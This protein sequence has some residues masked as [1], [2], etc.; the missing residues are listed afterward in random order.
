MN[1]IKDNNYLEHVK[2]YKFNKNRNLQKQIYN[3][4]LD[5]IIKGNL[6]SN[7]LLFENKISLAFGI[8]KTPV[9]EALKAL[10][11]D[12]LISIKPHSKT[13]VLPI[14]YQKVFSS[15]KI[16]EALELML[17]SEA[18]NNIEEK[19]FKI[20]DSIIEKQ[21]EALQEKDF[22]KFFEFDKAFHRQIAITAKLLDAWNI[23][24]KVELHL[25]RVRCLTKDD[26]LWN[27]SVLDE[28]KNILKAIKNKDVEIAK[29][30]LT[31]HL[32]KVSSVMNQ[33]FM[34]KDKI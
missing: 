21:Q 24:E 27:G 25:N 2:D 16:R 4:L 32:T 8:S 17:I 26:E 34:K 12:E 22:N 31:I 20:F 10:E 13:Y 7:T 33:I 6:K 18:I 28:H 23:L 1:F 29:L 5:L 15:Y 3:V 30:Q 14:N 9:R 11:S 19:D